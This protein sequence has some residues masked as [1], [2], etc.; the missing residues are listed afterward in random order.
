MF[1][2]VDVRRRH[3]HGVETET[4]AISILDRKSD[5]EKIKTRITRRECAMRERVWAR[6]L[7]GS[8]PHDEV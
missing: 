6:G 1:V 8:P 3:G 7:L 5:R 4:M 2:R